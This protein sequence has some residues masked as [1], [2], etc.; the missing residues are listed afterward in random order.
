MGS[1][2]RAIGA[3]W[4][5]EMLRFLRDKARVASTFVFPSVALFVL[6]SGLTPLVGDGHA[7][8]HVTYVQ[9]IFPGLIGMNAV[10]TSV[11]M[12]TSVAWDREFGFLRAALAAPIGRSAL[13]AGKV[14]GGS[15]IAV[16]QGLLV[17]VLAPLVGVSVSPLLVAALLG[18]TLLISLALTTT[19]L[20]I[21][22][23]I[24][25][26][27]GFH[28]AMQFAAMGM[29]FLGGAFFPIQ[30]VPAWMIWLASI[31]PATYA[32]DLLR[33]TMGQVQGVQAVPCPSLVIDGFCP[34]IMGDVGIIVA[35]GLA[36]SVAGVLL[37]TH[38][39]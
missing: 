18:P 26:I 8:R 34:G 21:A 12:G 29:V 2:L 36:T 10:M 25:S 32:I 4:Y 15:T 37:F 22:L 7:L 39:E 17:L 31:N 19:G 16:I 24:R 1:T 11:M 14:S 28:A 13:L 27:E 6:G 5:R 9:F 30:E 20:T 23:C 3:I 38:Q 35:L 33:R